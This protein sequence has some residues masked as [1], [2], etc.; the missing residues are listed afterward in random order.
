MS[1]P[2]KEG[3]AP[4]DKEEPAPAPRSEPEE[5]SPERDLVGAGGAGAVIG[6]LIGGPGGAALGGM[7]GLTGGAI[8]GGDKRKRRGWY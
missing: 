4:V 5:D 2:E 3:Q 7:L 8:R 6:G 1:T